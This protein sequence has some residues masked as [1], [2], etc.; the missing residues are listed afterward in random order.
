MLSRFAS[1]LVVAAGAHVVVA[2][3]L[4]RR[5]QDEPRASA[6]PTEEVVIEVATAPDEMI[7]RPR[8]PAA[9]AI[10][11]A[12]RVATF[13]THTRGGASILAPPASDGPRAVTTPAASASSWSLA[14]RAAPIDLGIGTY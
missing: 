5:A 4:A 10:D 12:P 14:S 7:A 11:P 6:P 13:E 1:A 8:M 9:P 3:A 2:L